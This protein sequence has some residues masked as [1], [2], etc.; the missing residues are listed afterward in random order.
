MADR[1]A[2]DRWIT[3]GVITRP[4]GVTGE[5]RVHLF[6]PDSTLLD[7]LDEIFLRPP[8]E[9]IP[10]LVRMLSW[11]RAPKAS[12]LRLEGVASREQAEE[13]R[14]LE[15]CIPRSVLPALDEG[16]FYFVD[17]I[18]LKVLHEGELVG[19]VVEVLDYPSVE[20]LK[21]RTAQGFVEI[22][23]LPQ[24]I[25]RVDLG[26]GEVHTLDLGDIPIQKKG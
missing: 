11:R 26:A 20:C 12:L 6:N 4:Q 18:G 2:E 16:E 17:L 8:E 9:E 23:N 14:G 5:L 3:L 13:L 24:W 25:E 21:V 22:P 19:E 7:G 10:T 1:A 15:L